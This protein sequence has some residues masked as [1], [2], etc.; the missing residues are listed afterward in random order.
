M[1]E[2]LEELV[3]F[4]IKFDTMNNHHMSLWIYMLIYFQLTNMI[5][6][7]SRTQSYLEEVD[8]S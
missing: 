6:R 7:A 4:G 2:V 3:I 8:D 5:K 1:T